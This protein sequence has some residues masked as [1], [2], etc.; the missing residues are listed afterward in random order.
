MNESFFKILG[1]WL[2]Y[3]SYRGPF[4]VLLV[5]HS[6]IIILS[7]VFTLFLISLSL[8]MEFSIL[9]HP[10]QRISLLLCHRS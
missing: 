1:L 5:L 2:G 10:L 4:L 7:V 8:S 6:V 9:L 3:R